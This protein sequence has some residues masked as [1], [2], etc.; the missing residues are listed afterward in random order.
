MKR[1]RP[2]SRGSAAPL[3]SI[4]IPTHDRAVT[5]PLSIQSALDQTVR[6]IEVVVVGDGC[7]DECR[8]VAHEFTARDGRVVFRDLPKAPLRGV[9]NRD[10]AVREARGSFI[11]YNDDDDLLLPHHVS[12]L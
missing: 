6:D 8:K 4:I 7:T 5:L 11:F 2:G 3:A 12:V 9:A 1:A 10:L